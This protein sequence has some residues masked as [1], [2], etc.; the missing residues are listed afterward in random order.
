VPTEIL[1]KQ[2]FDSIC[3]LLNGQGIKVGLITRGNKEIFNYNV[4]SKNKKDRV[5]DILKNAD[6]IIGTHA[7]IQDNI[8]F[9]NLSLVVIDEQHRFG[10]EQRSVLVR[11]NK[12]KDDKAHGF[13]PHLLSMTA[14]PIPRSLAM[15]LY[16]DLNISV[17]NEMPKDRKK[18]I[19]R[20][21]SEDKRVEAYK[22]IHD[23]VR[24][25]RQAFVVCP[26][27]DF[28][29]K[30]GVKSVKEEFEKLKKHVFPDLKIEML[31]GRMK[32]KEKEDV[33]QNFLDNKTNI[34]VSTSVVEV[35]VDVPNAGIM[36]IEGADRFGLAQ[37]H[38]F[39]GRVGRSNYQS[40]CL[41][42][43]ESDSSSVLNRLSVLVSN[44]DGFALAKMDLKF[45]GTKN[46]LTL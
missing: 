25:G 14:T 30:L 15:A 42:F 34:L 20:V 38:Q 2:H 19:T 26:L 9:R 5:F 32:T 24:K 46:S 17:I 11:A 33:M 6:I 37:L 7:L 31:H 29:D 13:I 45:R 39:R 44:H 12:G 43:T 41:L 10:V 35:G 8:N 28:S 36:M 16:G 27:I 18:I 4:Q 40:Y 23:E 1:A 21:V 22:F 3:K